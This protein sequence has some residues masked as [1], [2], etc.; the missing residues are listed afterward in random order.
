MA[1]RADRA[2][3]VFPDARSAVAVAGGTMAR[4]VE[5]GGTST[6]ITALPLSA[7]EL[8][9]LARLTGGDHVVAT[10]PSDVVDVAESRAATVLIA[11]GVATPAASAVARAAGDAALLLGVPLYRVTDAAAPDGPVPDD[12]PPA[13]RIDVGLQRDAKLDA[14]AVLGGATAATTAAAGAPTESFERVE[15][16]T[17]AP[18]AAPGRAASVTEANSLGNRLGTAALALVIGVVF[19][20]IGT[21]AHTTTVSIGGIDIPIGLILSVIAVV[22]LLVGLRLVIHDKLVVGACA[23]GVIGIV[24]LF[25]LPSAGGSVLIPQGIASVIWT[26]TPAFTAALVLAWPSLPPRAD[27]QHRA[28]A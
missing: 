1:N 11:P 9:A 20:A 26:V 16:R 14:L 23:V 27:H 8:D 13:R 17:S 3:F 28:T 21:V 18:S 19:G 15:E 7:G 2:V 4:V 12:R 10:G 25:T 6:L 5:E 22:S 24:A